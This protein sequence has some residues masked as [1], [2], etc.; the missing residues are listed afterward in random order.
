MFS[1]MYGARCSRRSTCARSWTTWPCS[2]EA[3]AWPSSRSKGGSLQHAF[4]H[5]DLTVADSLEITTIEFS[6][7]GTRLVDT[8][9]DWWRV[10]EWDLATGKGLWRLDNGGG[11]PHPL[12]ARY[13]S[14]GSRVLT[15]LH[16]HVLEARTGRSIARFH[17]PGA[18]GWRILEILPDERSGYLPTC[19]G[20]EV[21]DITKRE[22]R[23]VLSG[24]KAERIPPRTPR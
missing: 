19:A 23:L 13:S 14:D 20:I 6:P 1:T 8:G 18:A 15:N 2:R 22:L 21:Y 4:S 24:G 17:E 16:G 5:V 12:R 7:D 11:S 10:R 3:I 9:N